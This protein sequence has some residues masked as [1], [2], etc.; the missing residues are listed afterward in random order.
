MRQKASKRK[1][2]GKGNQKLEDISRT[3]GIK[4]VRKRGRERVQKIELHKGLHV[5]KVSAGRRNQK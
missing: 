3:E 1:S 2:G 5:D 4:R